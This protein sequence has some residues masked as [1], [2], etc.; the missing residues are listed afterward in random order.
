[1]ML[2]PTKRYN[3]QIFDC[4]RSYDT[5]LPNR[6]RLGRCGDFVAAAP[7]HDNSIASKVGFNIAFNSTLLIAIGLPLIFTRREFGA[8]RITG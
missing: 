4:L 5:P 8:N 6:S 7:R 2:L 1:M 3:R